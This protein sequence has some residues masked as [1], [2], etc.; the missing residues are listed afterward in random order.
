MFKVENGKFVKDIEFGIIPSKIHEWRWTVYKASDVTVVR[1]EIPDIELDVSDI[2]PSILF[3]CIN[4]S[5]AK[6][7]SECVGLD[8]TLDTFS[9][10]M[11][12]ITINTKK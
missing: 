11:V 7:Y 8:I 10:F 1:G 12:K 2:S 4:N 6:G 3:A 9:K 5:Y